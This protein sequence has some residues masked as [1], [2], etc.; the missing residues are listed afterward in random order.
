[1]CFLVLKLYPNML[2]AMNKH[3]LFMFYAV[4][5]L[6]GTIFVAIFLP[7]TQGKT[8]GEIEEYF[9]KKSN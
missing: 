2:E 4:M 7:E 9:A 1:M 3:G 8:L 5:S 6:V